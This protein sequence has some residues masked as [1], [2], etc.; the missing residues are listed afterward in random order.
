MGSSNSQRTY[1]IA[2]VVLVLLG[3]YLRSNRYWVDPIGLWGDEAVWAE[4]LLEWPIFRIK[5]RPLGYVLVTK[6]LVTELGVAEQSL[7]LLSYL[8]SLGTLLVAPYVARAL[9]RSRVAS[10]ALVLVLSLHPAVIDFAKEFKPYS[11]ELF[12]HL[13]LLA[14]YL[15]HRNATGR[16][17]L[18]LL[19][20]ALP[21]SFWFAYN[22][23]FTFPALFL[24]VGLELHR[25]RRFGDLLLTTV[26]ASICL[27]SILVAN[28]LVFQRENVERAER[29]WGAKYDSFYLQNEDDLTRVEWHVNKH[30]EL[31]AMPGALRGYWR[32]PTRP[33]RNIAQELDDAD[34]YLWVGLHLLGLFWLA[35]HRRFTPLL[36]LTAPILVGQAFNLLSRWPWGAF[37]VNLF[38]LAYFLPIAAAGIDAIQRSSPPRWR[39]AAGAA[40]IAFVAFPY[41]AFGFDSHR[42]KRAW[43]GHTEMSRLIQLLVEERK[44]TLEENPRAGRERV[45]MDPYTCWPWKFYLAHHEQTKN[46]HGEFLRKNYSVSCRQRPGDIQR[47]LRNSDRPIWIVVSDVRH[48]GDT[49]RWVHPLAEEMLVVDRPSYNH[50]ILRVKGKPH[51]KRTRRSGPKPDSH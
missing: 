40:L 24:L 49:E 26:S 32:R 10:F 41:F 22:A 31:A 33:L 37:R 44:A 42:E 2:V 50:L 20:A 5:Y 16:G 9:F 28:Y 43:V 3:I 35:R 1:R 45:F 7:R 17:W 23:L 25:K 48:V 15:R 30:A 12:V 19:L 36:L 34:T 13:G 4:R 51:P 29:R 46:E 38:L 27:G 11:V 47:A 21:L 8:A 39:T 14:L 6:W 18:Y